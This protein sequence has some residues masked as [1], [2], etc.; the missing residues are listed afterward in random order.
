MVPLGLSNAATVRAGRAFGR[1]DAKALRAGAKAA[2]LLG[3]GW[4]AVA[5]V[6]F[7]LL[8]E[9][10]VSLYIA[11][12][13]PLRAE[14]VA[15]GRGLLLV[16]ALF[17]LA[18]ATQVNAIALLRGMQDT[19]VPMWIAAASYWA[20]GASS[21]WALGIWLGFGAVGVWGGLVSGLTAAAV[22]LTAR[23]WLR[24]ATVSPQ[25]ARTAAPP[26]VAGRER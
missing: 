24:S 5:A 18:D 2:F 20:I 16:A 22:A 13:E 11:P 6:L 3:V 14:I 25:T 9:V 19:R 1:G 7:M 4:A 8:P 21:A 15:L 26:P 23:F 12:D 17:Q 10:L